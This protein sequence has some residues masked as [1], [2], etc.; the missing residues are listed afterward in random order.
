MKEDP[1]SGGFEHWPITRADLEPHYDRVE[2]MLGVQRYPFDHEPYASTSKTRALKEAADQLGHEWF[3]PN[4]AV[5]FANPDRPPQL[6]EAIVAPRKNLHQQGRATCR[7]CGECDVGCQ[8]GSKNTLDYT[9]L[10]S[11][12][13]AG[14]DIR[15]RSEVR[16]F[17]PHEGGGY[18]VHY[19]V[20]DPQAEDQP[21]DTSSLERHTLTCERL[22][23]SAGTMGST[24]LLLRNR[25]ALP[26]ISPLLG[27][28]FSGNGD[29]LTFAVR[30][31][32]QGQAGRRVPRVLDPGHGPVITSAIR[33]P[34][35]LDGDGGEG[36]GFYLEDAGY[37][38]FVSW[39]L[40]LAD[41][42]GAVPRAARIV[43]EMIL[44]RLGS[45][46]DPNLGDEVVELLGDTELASGV[47]PLLGMGRDVPDGNMTL[48]ERGCSQSTG[49][50]TG[51]QRSTSTAF[52]TCRP[53]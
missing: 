37:P 2:E 4:L 53:T 22:V 26:G 31:M 32:E 43:R 28:R 29:L 7:L 16:A 24:Y 23:L 47:L 3:L 39:M 13:H 38:E 35:A 6:G 44:D 48:D 50:S 41:A 21:T 51:G 52:A 1:G 46:H 12:W 17:E 19:V 5:T 30:C 49:A 27:T 40:Q 25:G 42:P 20:H 15:S 14:A 8:F 18:T 45:R 33:V 11:A 34:D 36:R 9:Y 10:T